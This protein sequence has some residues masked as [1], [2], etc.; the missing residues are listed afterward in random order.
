MSNPMFEKLI[1]KKKA[2]GKSMSP[3]HEKAK[4]TVLSD[5]MDHL[6]G[7]GMDKVKGM[8][9]VSVAS[10]SP[11]GLKAGLDKAKDLVSHTEEGEDEHDPEMSDSGPNPDVTDSD[12][13]SEGSDAEESGESPEMEASEDESS[14]D[15]KSHADKD[16]EIAQLKAELA[17][18]KMGMGRI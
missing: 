15:D 10:D 13:D 16:A 5:L 9:K 2:E 6:E 8:K 7:M 17:K 18:H 3:S 4:G 12:E 11:Q 1:A 14:E